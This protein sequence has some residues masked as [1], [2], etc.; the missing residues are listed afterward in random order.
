MELKLRIVNFLSK[1]MGKSLT[2]NEIAKS[3]GEYYS[4]V[5]RILGKLAEEEIV[6]KT[7]AGKSHI[8]SL[9]LNNEKTKTLLQLSEIESRDEFYNKNRELKL[10]LEDFTK[11][12]NPENVVTIVLFG[13]YAKG[14]ATKESDIDVLIV[15]ER[16]SG[17]DKVTKEIYAKYGKEI[18]AVMMTSDEFNKQKDRALI[19][20]IVASHCVLNGAE[21]F[22]KMVFGK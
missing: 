21:N 15:A 8:C 2:I 14:N 17:I 7:K 12:I 1:N 4:F 6:V 10:I 13:S 18:N 3:I 20:E 9:N 5:H 22:V 16:G 11:S 19:K